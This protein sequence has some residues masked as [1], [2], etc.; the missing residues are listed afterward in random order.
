MTDRGRRRPHSR[1]RPAEG[2]GRRRRHRPPRGAA[3]RP[4][5]PDGAHPRRVRRRR[6]VPAG[7][8][9]VVLLT[10]AEA[11][12]MFFRAPDDDLDQAEA[13][14]F[15]TPIFGEGVVFDAIRRAAPRDAPQPGAA[16]QVHAGPRRDH[17]HRG[18]RGWSAG[19]TTSGEIDLL[20]WF[21]ELT[22]YTS[23]ACLIGRS[24]PRAAR[25]PL[26]PPLPRPRAGHRRHR[27]RRRLRRHRELPRARRGPRRAW[28]S[29]CRRS[30]TGAPASRPPA[31]GRPRPARRPDVDQGRGRRRSASAPTSSPACS[32]R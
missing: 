24:V 9:D 19:G 17:R 5:R 32:S 12:E 15:M 31:E 6:R 20:D 16:R 1:A 4:D 25:R 13:Y 11:N 8:R 3:R 7:R 21:A 2:V 14:P 23:S 10:G 28:S 18:R 22:I 27:L 30:W 29:W 26:R